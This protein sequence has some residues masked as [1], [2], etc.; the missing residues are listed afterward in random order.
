MAG[1]ITQVILKRL[2]WLE[3]AKELKLKVL[4]AKQV[5]EKIVST[6][7]EYMDKA[8]AHMSC[9]EHEETALDNIKKLNEIHHR[10]SIEVMM[11]REKSEENCESAE[12][13]LFGER[14]RRKEAERNLK[15]MVARVLKIR[16]LVGG[17]EGCFEAVEPV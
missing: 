13:W 5:S 7:G 8:L 1:S 3:R 15:E 11:L 14:R 12:I 2:R 6:L 17:I 9:E 10:L 4:A 16:A